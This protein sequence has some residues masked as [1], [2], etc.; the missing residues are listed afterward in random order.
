MTEDAGPGIERF[1]DG[2][3]TAG[4]HEDPA[5]HLIA[6]A[7]STV[8]EYLD[9]VGELA[10]HVQTWTRMKGLHTP[11]PDGFC[12]ARICAKGGTGIA[13]MPWPCASRQLADW[14]AWIHVRSTTGAG[15]PPQS[16]ARPAPGGARRAAGG[17]PR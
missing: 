8:V 11:T 6:S 3:G 7:S 4:P 14:A 9:F 17:T 16:G 12:S 13:V 10:V 15:D 2:W 1:R 5:R